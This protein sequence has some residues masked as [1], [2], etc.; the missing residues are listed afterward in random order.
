MCAVCGDATCLYNMYN[1]PLIPIAM[2]FS[3]KQKQ[4]EWKAM[5][6]ACFIDT[7]FDLSGQDL[8]DPSNLAFDQPRSPQGSRS[9]SFQILVT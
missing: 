8:S 9:R 5:W 6:S 3:D 2:I 7:D 1:I 4:D